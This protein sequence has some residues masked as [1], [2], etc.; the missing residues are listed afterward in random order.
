MQQGD[1][2]TQH[3]RLS[4][5][6]DCSFHISSRATCAKH[7]KNERADASFPDVALA[8]ANAALLRRQ[9]EARVRGHANHLAH[10]VLFVVGGHEPDT[11]M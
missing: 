8:F 7:L 5:P 4:S 9:S 10:T 1:V 11:A 6:S 3:H 2:Q